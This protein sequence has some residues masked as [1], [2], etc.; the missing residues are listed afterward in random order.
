[1]SETEYPTSTEIYSKDGHKRVY[2]SGKYIRDTWKQVIDYAIWEDYINDDSRPY[3]IPSNAPAETEFCLQDIK[4]ICDY[5]D[6]QYELFSNGKSFRLATTKDCIEI[7][8][9]IFKG[10]DHVYIYWIYKI[11]I[12][13]GGEKVI[14]NRTQTK[15]H[16]I[17]VL[18]MEQLKQVFFTSFK[19]TDKT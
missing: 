8:A 18:D 6:V 10:N 2:F 13:I 17:T 3:F 16:A 1:M 19:V 7:D 11:Y 9:V 5:N 15:E 14:T 12:D 4:D